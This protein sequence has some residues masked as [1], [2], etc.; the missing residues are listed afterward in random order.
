VT[1]VQKSTRLGDLLVE[2]R[3]ITRGQLMHAIELQ[4]E[5]R[6]Q[7]IQAGDEA[8]HRHELGEIL[9]ELGY[10]TRKQLKR[11]LGWQY[12]LRKASF[13]MALF[14]PLLTAAC[15]GGGGSGASASP[16]PRSSVA[17]SIV[18]M[19]PAAE[20]SS[21]SSSVASSST[22]A[23]KP[24]ASS[25]SSVV[26]SPAVSSSSSV[27]PP[28]VVSSSS[29]AVSL[30]AVSSSSSSA[31]SSSSSS[32]DDVVEVDGQVAVYWSPPTERENGEYL[33]LDEIGGY[34]LRYK[35]KSD[36]EFTSIFIEDGGADAYYFDD[37]EG[38]YEFELATFD[39]AGLY[40]KFVKVTPY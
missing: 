23:G 3:I 26:S 17:S 19:P 39:T 15:G 40:S 31:V 18:E 2:R 11:G 4:Q 5:R 16:L 32:A 12:K 35:C 36:K 25:S 28:P 14:A 33:E 34:E 10:I 38:E 30:P 22:Q 1:E 13:A 20:A 9:I 8:P 24:E 6:L 29:S 37:L 7:D 27:V 21:V